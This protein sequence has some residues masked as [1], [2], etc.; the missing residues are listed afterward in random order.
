MLTRIQLRGFRCFSALRAEL[1]PG[2]SVFVGANAQGKTSIL[3]AI[4]VLMRLQS[5]RTV[6][7]ADLVQCG[8]E[9]FSVS[10]T[11]EGRNLQVSYA[12]GRRRQSCEGNP[13]S[14]GMD[15]LAEAGRVVW[16]GSDDRQL[17]RGSGSHRRRY[18]DFLASQLY[19][20]YR[21]ALVRYERVL[22]ARN[23]LLRRNSR[24]DWAGIDAH[25]P[26]LVREGELLLRRREDL[27]ARLE[28]FVADSYGAIGGAAEGFAMR[29]RPS[30]PRTAFGETL[31]R[32]RQND[33]VRRQTTVG[34]HRDGLDLEIGGR[35]AAMFASEGQ[36]RTLALALK[37][38]QATLLKE[39]SGTDPLLL[40]DDVFGELDRDRR[41]ALFAA[42]PATGQRVLT[43]TDLDWL[44]DYQHLEPALYRVARG[45]LHRLLTGA[46]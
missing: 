6:R 11:F 31:D 39:A 16:M 2:L 9:G 33:S 10:G 35:Q 1:P 26:I 21:P 38:A 36:Q 29:Y 13:L 27:S 20:D 14:R 3:E 22:R 44:P 30:V 25:D 18:L 8:A 15:Y 23:A 17:V 32:A 7:L 37:L 19:S 24:P 41:K 43:T 42:L 46:K 12:E 28:G 45:A 40:L 4:G 34:P 5:P